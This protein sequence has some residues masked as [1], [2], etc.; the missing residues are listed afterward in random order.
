MPLASV[1][2]P[3]QWQYIH[4]PREFECAHTIEYKNSDAPT[5]QSGELF[6]VASPPTRLFN[7]QID[8]FALPLGLDQNP[9]NNVTDNFFP[10]G[11]SRGGGFPESGNIMSQLFNGSAF[12]GG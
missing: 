6:G 1:E 12:C 9:M 8:G 2:P 4:L 5:E 7:G 10:L 3:F 11:L